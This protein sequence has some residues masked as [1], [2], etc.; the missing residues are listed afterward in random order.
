MHTQVDAL[1]RLSL[2]VA[3]LIPGRALAAIGLIA[4]VNARSPVVARGLSTVID[5]MLACVAFPENLQATFSIPGLETR[6]D[7]TFH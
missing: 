1:I 3:T 2:T 5:V 6:R 7:S 4:C